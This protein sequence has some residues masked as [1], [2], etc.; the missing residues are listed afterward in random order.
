[1]SIIRLMGGASVPPVIGVLSVSITN[2][3]SYT[4]NSP[5]PAV[6]F[7]NTGTGGTGAAATANVQTV[8]TGGGWDGTVVVSAAWTDPTTQLMNTLPSNNGFGYT[9]TP[10][11][12][13]NQ[14]GLISGPG[15]AVSQ[16]IM[17]GYPTAITVGGAVS[18]ALAN[19]NYSGQIFNQSGMHADVTFTNSGGAITSISLVG[20]AISGTP[21]WPYNAT[22]GTSPD[23]PVYETSNPFVVVGKART[24]TTDLKGVGGILCTGY[25]SSTFNAVPT[26]TIG[27]P[28]NPIIGSG[29]VQAALNF[30]LGANPTT[31]THQVVSVAITNPGSGYLA[32][33]TVTFTGGDT[34]S[35][36]ATGTAN[37]GPL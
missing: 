4:T 28:N 8:I 24:V 10:S 7:N 14:P 23:F 21:S 33:P 18:N 35:P 6:V 9:T 29:G 31:T 22:S 15:L 27:A 32:A 37:I 30:V 16:V 5:P 36:A 1:M 19:G 20:G 3:G 25:A 17:L 13:I 26:I 11:F 2:G 34:P 12:T